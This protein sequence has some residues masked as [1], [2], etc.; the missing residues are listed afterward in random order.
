M[1]K[2]KQN[3]PT[4]LERIENHKGRFVTVSAR[5]NGEVSTF[6]AKVVNISPNYVTFNNVNGGETVK[7]AKTSLV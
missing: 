6:C 2:R 1:S 4:T 7:V 5:R 3:T